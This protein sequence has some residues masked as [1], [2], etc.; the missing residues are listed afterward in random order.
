M[1]DGRKEFLTHTSVVN[2]IIT[3]GNSANSCSQTVFVKCP[4]F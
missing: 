1:A 2:E 3:L 4:F